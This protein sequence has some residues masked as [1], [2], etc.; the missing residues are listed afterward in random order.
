MNGTTNGSALRIV[1][2]CTIALT[3]AP[4]G[5]RAQDA[6]PPAAADLIQRFGQLDRDR[7]NTVVRNME[8]RLQ[9]HRDPV[10]RRVF[11]FERGI[12]SYPEHEQIPFYDTADYA[13]VAKQR[14][15][16][17]A[18]SSRHRQGTAGM[19]EIE[20]LPD[21]H[22]RVV[23][24]WRTGKVVRVRDSLS[25]AERFENYVRGYL[26]G[27][28]QAIAQIIGD[29]DHDAAQRPL[30]EFFGHLYADRIGGVYEGVTMFAAWNSG[31]I[32]E[33][34]DTDAIAFAR[35]V[36][37]TRSFRAPIPPDRRRTRLYQKIREGFQE[38]RVYRS[39]VLAAAAA[40]VVADPIID[41]RYEPLIRR[42]R[43]LWMQCDYE[44][45][46]FRE[47]LVAMG[48]RAT[49]MTEIDDA[50]RN[51]LEVVE[52]ERK[53]LRTRADYLRSLADRELKTAGS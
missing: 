2:A 4:A 17:T 48:D 36:R 35:H 42:S 10:L 49:F 12:R 52:G 21:L 15:L 32:V 45:P 26:P 37:H 27:A 20:F 6:P 7:Q 3:A 19:A 24:D 9:R 30:A 39:L 16:V 47:R 1:A 51:S 40:Y 33:V 29:L 25:D 50:I 14:S 8:R 38:H 22:A 31:K 13:P 34:P 41:A 11:M 18:G 5:L 28:D 23:Y 53:A 44:V 46:K 43:W